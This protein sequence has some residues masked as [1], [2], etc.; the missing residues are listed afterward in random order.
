MANPADYTAQDLQHLSTILSALHDGIAVPRQITDSILAALLKTTIALQERANA[1]VPIFE[2]GK[3]YRVDAPGHWAHGRDVLV[4]RVEHCRAASMAHFH[5]TDDSPGF[6]FLPVSCFSV[7][8]TVAIELG[9]T[10]Q[11]DE[12][13]HPYHG[14]RVVVDRLNKDLMAIVHLEAD[15]RSEFPLRAVA[16]SNL[17]AVTA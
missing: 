3:P 12:I 1:A 16:A 4:D 17:K 10:Y 7:P 11:V 14:Q 9:G 6:S 2:V 13:I 5:T 15:T 8:S